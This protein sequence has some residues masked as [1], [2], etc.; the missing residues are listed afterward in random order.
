MISMPYSTGAQRH[1]GA[2]RPAPEPGTVR[3]D[4][5]RPVRRALRGRRQDRPR[6]V[7]L[8]ASVPG[9]PSAPQ[10]IF[11]QGA[12]AY[13]LAPGGVARRP[14]ARSSTGTRRTISAGQERRSHD[15]RR[16]SHD[17]DE[18]HPHAHRR[19]GRGPARPA[20]P[21]LSRVLVFVAAPARRRWRTPGFTRSRPICAATARPIGPA[22]ID[23]YTLLHLVGD[24][25]GVL[26]ALGAETAVI[27]GHDWGAPVAWHAALLRPDRFR[28]VIGLSVPFRPR[29]S[30]R[31]DDGHAAEPTT[32]CSISSISRNPG[33]AEAE[34][35]RDPRDRP[36]APSCSALPG[37][38]P[39]RRGGK[40]VGMVPR[41]R[42]LP[43][44]ACPVR[45]CCLL[46]HARPTRFLRRRIRAHRLSRRPQLVPQHRPQLGAAR[47][48]RRAA[49]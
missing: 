34:L 42:R 23:Q 32:R 39:P 46:A 8:P 47:A 19:A 22:E 26:D 14:A 18:R 37:T 44:A 2:A 41:Q 6:D 7:D 11:R 9:R 13:Q 25:V 49:R 48:F 29:G 31:P 3:P 30:S 17:R 16:A 1:S 24:M 4:D 5:L 20:L 27:A 21:R 33:V 28:G 12:R 10:Q 45:R 38:T 40:P 15:R 43:R 36:S 35:E